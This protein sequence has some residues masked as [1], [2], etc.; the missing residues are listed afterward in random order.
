MNP[1]YLT[2]IYKSIYNISHSMK[3]L[4]DLYRKYYYISPLDLAESAE[5]S[6][7]LY[8]CVAL[9]FICSLILTFCSF[10]IIHFSYAE[11]KILYGFFIISFIFSIV[12]F[13]SSI[14]VRNA[15]REKAYI[16]KK[17]PIYILFLAG[18]SMTIYM[19]YLYSAFMGMMVFFFSITLFLTV[20]YMSIP[21]FIIF[22]SVAICLSSGLYKNFSFL[23]VLSF[24]FMIFMLFA[25][26][27]YKRY[28]EKQFLESIKMQKKSLE[29]RTFGNFTPMYDKKVI[30]FSRSKSPELLAYLI[31]KNGS[32]TNTKELI[33][34]LYG[35]HADSSR[36]GASLRLLISDIK[37]TLSETGV[38]NFF[39]TEYNNF[40][41]N[42][43]V[44]QCDYYD[45]LAGEPK[46]V[47][48]FTGEFMSQYSWAEDA[49]AFLEKK[50]VG[51]R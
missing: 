35:E 6:R 28:K 40:R 31:Y 14:L 30:K 29:V 41:I 46:A 20:S 43:E 19:F 7:F 38:Q 45:F 27:L 39:I 25:Y 8:F 9:F 23:G 15:P 13:V 48:S 32:S 49:L 17:I 4:K 47:K 44:V 22:T 24:W 34:V 51:A 21:L 1:G 5:A 50:A 36:Y 12:S 2:H 33:S 26:T 3:F 42:P 37:H 10:P 16:L 18:M 11:N